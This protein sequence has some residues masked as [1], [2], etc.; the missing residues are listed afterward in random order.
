MVIHDREWAHRLI[1]AARAF[2]V[3]LPE[4]IGT[5]VFKPL[6]L[7]TALLTLLHQL[8]ATKNP[9]N[10]T[11]RQ[12]GTGLLHQSQTIFRAPASNR[13]HKGTTCCST[14]SAVLLTLVRLSTLLRNALQPCAA[15]TLQPQVPC[16]TRNLKLFAETTEGLLLPRRRHHKLHPLLS[17]I[18]RL[19]AHLPSHS[20]ARCARG[21]V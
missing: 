21:R 19:P 12:F 13:C 17:Y 18:H 2:E 5:A 7:P 11:C 1:P 4:L 10:R 3:H 6:T 14:H 15:V 8:V 20:A 9:V 16:R